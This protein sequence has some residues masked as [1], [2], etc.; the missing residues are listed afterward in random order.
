MDAACP[1]DWLQIPCVSD[2]ANSIVTS[3][4]ATVGCASKL[5]GIIGFTVVANALTATT[6]LYSKSITKSFRVDSVALY[7]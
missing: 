4:G 3:V 1:Y 6:S 2:Q 7:V 5:C